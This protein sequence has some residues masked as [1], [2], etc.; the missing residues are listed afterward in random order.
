M[1]FSMFF[2]SCG[3]GITFITLYWKSHKTR[4]SIILITNGVD[5]WIPIYM[6]RTMGTNDILHS[7]II[8]FIPD[9]VGTWDGETCELSL[10]EA[11]KAKVGFTYLQWSP[12]VVFPRLF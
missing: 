10:T 12:F 6:I 7:L 5:A 11:A 3:Y 8:L 4:Q 2:T 9:V 1:L